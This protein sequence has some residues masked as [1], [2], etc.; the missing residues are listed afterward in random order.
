MLSLTRLV[1]VVSLAAAPTMAQTP[2]PG[3]APPSL[4]ETIAWDSLYVLGA[5]RLGTWRYRILDTDGTHDSQLKL[6]E[7][8]I[9]IEDPY[10]GRVLIPQ[11]Y[12]Q[13]IGARVQ[14]AT[15][16]RNQ[17]VNIDM[18]RVSFYAVLGLF[19]SVVVLVALLPLYVYR[20][21]YLTEL[22]KRRRLQES[23]SQLA[24]SRED[25]RRQLAREL[26]DGPLQDLH[27]LHMQ[28]GLAADALTDRPD[29]SAKPRVRG[30]QDDAFTVVM[31]LRRIT[32]ALRPPALGPFGLAAALAAHTDRFRHRHPSIE[33]TVDLDADGLDLF[34]STRLALFR[35]AQ[36]AMNNAVK[37]GPPT[38]LHVALDLSDDE[39][40]LTIE[41]DG[42]G[43]NT[44][45]DLSALAADGHFGLL[46]MQERADA[47]SGDLQVQNR[48]EGGLRV[49]VS[50]P[51][52]ADSTGEASRR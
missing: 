26:H 40:S 49:H 43:L 6:D 22:D 35:I 11:F 21:R 30:A 15:A 47:V 37:H 33:V 17:R 5:N 7:I 42:P 12:Q 18:P 44:S 39:V 4:R 14:D 48:P 25:E 29:D 31:D 9:E 41:D 38:I 3:P 2:T 8:W 1:F 36:E 50:V 32:E 46:G 34:E 28:L 13:S 20:R 19:A 45:P 23:K 24:E 16:G 10:G 27:A 52:I 51:R